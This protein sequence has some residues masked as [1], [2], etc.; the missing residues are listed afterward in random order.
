MPFEIYYSLLQ[1]V[2]YNR[3][4]LLCLLLAVLIVCLLIDTAIKKSY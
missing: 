1:F 4:K 2:D 3:L